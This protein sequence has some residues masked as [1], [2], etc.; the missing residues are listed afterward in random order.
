MRRKGKF[1]EK[2]KKVR[3]PLLPHLLAL[4]HH[5][6]GLQIR[7]RDAVQARGNVLAARERGRRRAPPR[8]TQVEL[9]N[10]G[11]ICRPYLTKFVYTP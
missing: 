10:R 11:L 8:N 3:K 7:R 2:M 5:R 4:S 1:E 6:A 9:Q